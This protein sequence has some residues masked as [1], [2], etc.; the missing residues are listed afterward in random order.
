MVTGASTGIGRAAVKVLIARG[1]R[2]FAGVRKPADADSL[3]HEFG[4]RVV[5]LLFDV[6]DAEAVRAAAGE[7]R[8]KLGGRTL[9][10]LVNNAGMAIGGPLALQ[11]LEEIRRV[12][13]VNLF[14]AIT[15]SQAM[16]PRLAADCTLTGGPGR[17]VNITSL[18][19]LDR[20]SFLGEDLPDVETRSGGVHR[21]LKARTDDLRHRRDRD[22]S[23]GRRHPD[24]GQGRR[25]RRYALRELGLRRASEKVQG[26]VLRARTQGSSRPKRSARR[27]IS[28]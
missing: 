19:G 18:G 28:P 27:P 22:R 9:K 17:I 16:I 1:W 10:G 4:D 2:A 7:I 25:G 14:G 21:Q 3:R 13:E 24:L 8:A 5:P 15:V 26:A 23:G 6:T 11:P 12:F 20:Y